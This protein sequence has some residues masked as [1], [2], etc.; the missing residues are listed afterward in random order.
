VALLTALLLAA[1]YVPRFDPSHA[2]VQLDVGQGDAA[3]FRRGRSA[4]LI[5]VGP[6]D[7]YD[8]LRYLRHEGLFVDAV[9]LSHLDEDHAGALASLLASE[10]D[11]PAIVMADGAIDD[12]L[13]SAVENGLDMA[14]QK[15]IPVHMVRGIGIPRCLLLFVLRKAGRR[16]LKKA[17]IRFLQIQLRVRKCKRIHFPKPRKLFLILRRRIIQHLFCCFVVFDLIGKHLIVD[18]PHTAKGPGKQ[19]PL[20]FIRIDPELEGHVCH[21]SH[22]LRRFGLSPCVS[23]Y[24]RIVSIGAPPVEIRQKL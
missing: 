6:D 19:I 2:Y 14:L 11:V 22:F 1:S 12:E 23:M 3:L 16:I 20:F 4:V 9:L 7:C 8:M 10:I 13:S 18:E 24:C 5:D 21:I 17:L 15:G